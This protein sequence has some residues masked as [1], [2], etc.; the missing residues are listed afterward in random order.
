[1]EQASTQGL[2]GALFCE[3]LSTILS[4]SLGFLCLSPP[5]LPLPLPGDIVVIETPPPSLS[6]YFSLA[7][8]VCFFYRY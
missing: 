6:T 7:L 3:K 4:V 2:N 8:L 5:L 1:M